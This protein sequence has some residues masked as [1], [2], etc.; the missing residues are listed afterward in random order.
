VRRPLALAV[1]FAVTLALTAPAQAA[2]AGSSTPGNLTRTQSRALYEKITS[3]LPADARTR[4]E[5]LRDRLEITDDSQV[6]DVINAVIDPTAHQCADT[7][8]TTYVQGLTAGL[9]QNDLLN[10]AVILIYDPLDYDALFFPEPPAQ[11]HFGLDGEYTNRLQ[12]QFTRL[13]GF[14]DI[15][16]KGIELVPV[17][18]R[19]LLDTTRTARA[20]KAE[21]P[22][23]ADDQVAGLADAFRE[24]ADQ[25]KFDHG[26]FPLFTFNAFA[27]SGKDEQV[28]GGGAVSDKILV[29]D[30]VLEGMADLGLDDIAPE[31]ILSH[32]YGHHLQF[33]QGLD[34]LTTLTGPEASRRLELMADTFGSYSL[35]HVLGA[36]V[37]I[38]RVKEFVQM[39]FDLGD[40]QFAD[41]GHH[42]TPDQRRKAAEF[43]AVNALLPAWRVLPS[44]TVDARFEKALPKITS[45]DVKAM[46]KADVS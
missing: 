28:P 5:A 24:I 34:T 27:A 35:T 26:D 6:G 4:V 36:H 46:S 8:V 42:G 7:P 19:T 9:D 18:G 2:P 23:L 40:C 11:R 30:G 16:G 38:K 25:D 31:A 32:E 15:D 12:R 37:G 43:G 45:P 13:K 20:L 39:F 33:Q 10:L 3:L 1:A 21:L 14:W 44:R 29:G 41:N 22:G 17:H